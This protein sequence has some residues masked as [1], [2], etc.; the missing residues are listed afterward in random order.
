MKSLMLLLLASATV[1]VAFQSEHNEC[2][3]ETQGNLGGWTVKNVCRVP[4]DVGL[5]WR[6]HGS[7]GAWSVR[8]ARRLNPGFRVDT[9]NCA[10]CV[11]D[12][13]FR[14]F[15]SSDRVSDSLLRPK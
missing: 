8:V 14:S 2:V 1:C 5:A 11:M 15:Y 13:E 9:P 12:M 7:S 3:E 4:I 10:Q 6:P